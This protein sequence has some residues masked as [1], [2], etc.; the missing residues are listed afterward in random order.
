M[1]INLYNLSE[2][3]LKPNGQGFFLFIISLF[4]YTNR[5]QKLK[6]QCI[7]KNKLSPSVNLFRLVKHIFKSVLY[8]FLDN[9][10]IILII[11]AF[12]NNP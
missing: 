2:C 10:S 4:K 8:L 12:H 3:Y 7:N 1:Q 11:S 6:Y 5:C 9:K